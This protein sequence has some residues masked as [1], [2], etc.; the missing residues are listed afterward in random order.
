MPARPGLAVGFGQ[1]AFGLGVMYFSG[2][3]EMLIDRY[4]CV[5][6]LGYATAFVMLFGMGISMLLKW[7]SRDN[8]VQTEK[9]ELEE[10][11]E[12]DYEMI[13]Q[14]TNKLSDKIELKQLLIMRQFWLAM[15]TVMTSQLG[16]VFVAY[17]Y[18]IGA[19]FKQPMHELV[20]AF[21]YISFASAFC[22]PISGMF[23]DILKRSKGFFEMGARNV[24]LIT[25]G[26]QVGLF[27]LLIPISKY[28]WY[29]GF[30]WVA[31]CVVLTFATGECVAA[32]LLRD[33]FGRENSSVVLGAGISIG[34][35]IG[36]FVPTVVLEA[37][38][39]GKELENGR[40]PDMYVGFY[41]I[42]VVWA[43][44]GFA[45]TVLLKKRRKDPIEENVAS[46]EN[47]SLVRPAVSASSYR[48]VE[49]IAGQEH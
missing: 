20:R 14:R 23:A 17:F 25:I 31:G 33:M 18:Q 3:F 6:A 45:A 26:L 8:S 42:C 27:A 1:T 4:G 24:L 28:E 19:S 38:N 9:M 10:K 48:A 49:P 13:E 36:C 37:I 39:N 32:L 7:P 16:F 5:H 21:E 43:M 12:K 44:I 34:F 40:G 30:V 46:S 35:G 2:M 47:V 15:I 11:Q 29:Q 22:R 41:W